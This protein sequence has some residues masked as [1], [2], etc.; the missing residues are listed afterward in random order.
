[1]QVYNDENETENYSSGPAVLVIQ[2]DQKFLKNPAAIKPKLDESILNI[3][4]N[5]IKNC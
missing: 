5:Q 4:I 2:V 3:K 1:M